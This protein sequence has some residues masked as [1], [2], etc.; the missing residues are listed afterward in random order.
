GIAEVR[1]WVL[2]LG[3]IIFAVRPIVKVRVPLTAGRHVVPV[4]L[5]P[6][7]DWECRFFAHVPA[8]DFGSCL[9]AEPV[10]F[11][12]RGGRRVC[13]FAVPGGDSF[14]IGRTVDASGEPVAYA[15]VRQDDPVALAD[16]VARADER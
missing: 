15:E 8:T 7:S 1:A 4:V 10:P 11:E 2:P 6:H 13:E 14:I 16:P 9:R 3:S 12:D 5:P